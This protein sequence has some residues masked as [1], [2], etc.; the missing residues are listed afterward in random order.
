MESVL[1]ASHMVEL[2]NGKIILYVLFVDFVVSWALLQ[3]W[4]FFIL[5]Y[6]SW[7]LNSRK[8]KSAVVSRLLY[9]KFFAVNNWWKCTWS[10]TEISWENMWREEL[11]VPCLSWQNGVAWVGDRWREVDS[12]MRLCQ[13]E[14]PVSDLASI[15]L[16]AFLTRSTNLSLLFFFFFFLEWAATNLGCG[17]YFESH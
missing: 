4:A 13:G 9:V 10:S 2:N 6:K 1:V 5:S 15:E 14:W 11:K 12:S 8:S 7:K 17:I 3:Y 16:L